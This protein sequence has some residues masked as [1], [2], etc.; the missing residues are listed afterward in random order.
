[1]SETTQKSPQYI[2]YKDIAILRAKEYNKKK[3]KKL[4]EYARNRYKNLTQEE[5]DILVENRKHGFT[6][7]AKKNKMKWEEKQESMQKNRYYNHSC[8]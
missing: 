6:D 8:Y 7:N 1:M 2:R 4:K 3:I 5:K